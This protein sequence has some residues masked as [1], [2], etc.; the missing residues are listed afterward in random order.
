MTGSVAILS[1]G[2]E[3]RDVES[4]RSRLLAALDGVSALQ[5]DVSAVAAADTAGAQLLLSLQRE[6]A[7][8]GIGIEF[9]GESPVLTTIVKQLGLGE[10]LHRTVVHG[11]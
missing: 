2:L 7:A 11:R 6:A 9:V 5:V 1:P 4:A 10:A 3:I 8:R